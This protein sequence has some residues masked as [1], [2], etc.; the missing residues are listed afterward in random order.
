[1]Q[2]VADV[3]TRTTALALAG[4]SGMAFPIAAGSAQ[5]LTGRVAQS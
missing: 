4:C 2:V 3:V 1:M 5:I